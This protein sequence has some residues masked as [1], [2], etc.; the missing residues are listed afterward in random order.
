MNHYEAKQEARRARLEAA[1][2]RAG[3]RAEAAYKRAD[4]REEVSGI[5]FG[6][7][8][9]VGHHSER[10]HR[11]A[12]ERADNAMRKS[13]EESNRARDLAA[14]AAAVGTG[15]ISADD[16]DA[17]QKLTAEISEAKALQDFMRAANAHIRKAVKAGVTGE[18]HEGFPAYLAALQ[19]LRPSFKAGTAAKLLAPDFCGRIG[20]ADYQLTNN[21]A[22]I[23]RMEKRLAQ[24]QAARAVAEAAGG[25][26]KRTSYQG[27]CDV[28]ENFE[29]NRLQII[30]DGKP[31][32]ATRDSLKSAGFRWA[33]SQGAWQRQLSNGAR[34]AAK[35]FLRAQ[36]VEI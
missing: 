21:G 16:P 22:N 26:N 27:V 25:E 28:V 17:I 6:Q 33:P 13:I 19:A 23:R 30:F 3:Q 15:G 35:V 1:A 2:D 14:K 8:V 31:D 11:A 9:L 12:I 29:E 18:A 32:A 5:P 7:P 24:L 10:R 20:F 34:Y 4:L 36:G